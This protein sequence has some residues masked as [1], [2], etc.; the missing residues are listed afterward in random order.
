MKKTII[1]NDIQIIL[2]IIN[3]TEKL[4]QECMPDN[5][6]RDIYIKQY[7]DATILCQTKNYEKIV[8]SEPIYIG[9]RIR[10]IKYIKQN[11]TFLLALETLGELGI[12][13]KK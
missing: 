7:N 3:M 4:F 8:Y 5:K 11:K 6:I 9:Q 10:D 2:N 12:L 1:N 13:S